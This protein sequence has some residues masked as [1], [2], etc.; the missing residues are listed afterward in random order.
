MIQEITTHRDGNIAG[1]DVVQHIQ[2]IYT[3]FYDDEIVRSAAEE[4]LSLV[5][6]S[7]RAEV[8]EARRLGIA[9]GA[10]S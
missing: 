5:A 6:N 4:L 2:A 7:D 3:R 1:M 8:A 9:R 10:T